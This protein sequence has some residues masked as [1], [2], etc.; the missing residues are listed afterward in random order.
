MAK[1]KVY[2]NTLLQG[3]FYMNNTTELYDEYVTAI[4]Y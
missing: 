1:E 4:N 3:L 2:D